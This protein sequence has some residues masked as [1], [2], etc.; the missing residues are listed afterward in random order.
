MSDQQQYS[1]MKYPCVI[2]AVLEDY[3]RIHLHFHRLLEHLPVERL[4]FI[5]PESLK[6]AI[7]SD[8]SAGI[9]ASEKVEF[10]DERSLIPIDK[11]VPVYNE[12]RPKCTQ[13]NPSSI[14]WYYQQFLK[15]TYSKV[16]DAE[17]YLCWDSDT[18]PLRDIQMFSSSGKPYLDVKTEFQNSYFL[19]IEKLLGEHKIIEKSFISEH[20]LFNTDLMLELIKEIESKPMD[21]NAF[22]EKILFAVGPDNLRTGFSEFETYGTWIGLRHTSKYTLRNWF[23]FRN[24]NFFVDIADLTEDDIAWLSKDY[25]AATFEKYQPAQAEFT[26]LFRDPRYRE[27]L[28]PKQ[29]YLSFLES[30]ILG[31]YENGMIKVGDQYFPA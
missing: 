22:Y 19:T 25:D 3:I 26:E 13:P 4:V 29:F 30:G 31:D 21:G 9:L 28:T 16:C 11:L 14:N 1:A 15:M 10:I 27:K 12:I 8:I 5:G 23:S 7:D 17:Y 20:M 24:A 2:P 18:V 6:T